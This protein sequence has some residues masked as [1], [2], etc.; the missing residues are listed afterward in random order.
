[1]AVLL[2]LLSAC[3]YGV[4][5]FLGGIFARRS[6]AWQV[7]TTGQASSTLCITLAALVVAGAP[8]GTDFAWGALAGTGS[9]LGAAFL[10]RGLAGATMSVVAPISAVGCAL[11][12]VL[13]GLAL[14]E[15]PTPTAA[16]GIVLAF[17]AIALISFVRD[18]DPGHRGGVLDGVLAGVGFGLMFIALGR[19]TDDAGLAPLALMYLCS[20][21]SVVAVATLLRQRWRPRVAADWRGAVM[22]PIGVT[23]VIAFYLATKHGLLSIVAVITA[24]YPAS[25]VL[26][27]AALLKERVAPWQSLGLVVAALAVGLVAWG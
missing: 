17:P 2:S 20:T 23:A 12:P 5:D 10:Y 9:G 6:T 15:R 13:A 1:V 22:G 3:A 26:L 16:V 21:V 8:V 24:L 18:P 11:L 25:T 4:S 14:G 7:A 27:A 19:T